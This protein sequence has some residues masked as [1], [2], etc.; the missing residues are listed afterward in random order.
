MMIIIIKRSSVYQDR[1]G[2][3]IDIGNV[4]KKRA[5]V[6]REGLIVRYSP[7]ALKS[8]LTA[9]GREL[10]ARGALEGRSAM[11]RQLLGLSLAAGS[12][13]VFEAA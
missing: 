3:N 13:N 4:E 10:E 7:F 9:I 12:K 2:T 8:G 1:H 11:L 6:C 5:I